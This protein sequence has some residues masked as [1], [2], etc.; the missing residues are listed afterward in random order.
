MSNSNKE[1]AGKAIRF[2]RKYSKASMALAL[3]SMRQFGS[4]MPGNKAVG[5]LLD[6]NPDLSQ[7]DLKAIREGDDE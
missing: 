7:D 5:K 6:D 3:A 2:M 4:R 1:V